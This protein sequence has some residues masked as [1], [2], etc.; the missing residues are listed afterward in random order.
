M[1]IKPKFN[2][3]SKYYAL[4]KNIYDKEFD[5]FE[6]IADAAANGFDIYN[7]FYE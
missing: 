4:E 3:N 6:M 2:K 1:V 7:T 5:R